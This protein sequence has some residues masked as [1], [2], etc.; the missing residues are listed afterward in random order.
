[1]SEWLQENNQKMVIVNV[2]GEEHEHQID[3]NK[4][5]SET[6]RQLARTEG[7][8]SVNVKVDGTIIDPTQG[9]KK[10]AELGQVEI[11]PKFVGAKE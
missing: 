10:L 5:L 9:T 11:T 8:T 6:V 4:T 1:M 7:F 3:A 2:N